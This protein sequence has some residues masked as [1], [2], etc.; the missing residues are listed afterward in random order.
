MDKLFLER[1]KTLK[2]LYA[3]DEEGIRNNIAA[4]LRYYAKEVIEA[5]NGKVALSLYHTCHPDI[6]ITDV[7]MPHM[8]GIETDTFT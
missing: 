4:S 5:D 8:S 7:L 1:L 3:E 2:I 6:V